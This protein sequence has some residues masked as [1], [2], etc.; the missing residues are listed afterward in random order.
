MHCNI[1]KKN[2]LHTIE[3]FIIFVA[4][5]TIKRLICEY[6]NPVLYIH[7]DGDICSGDLINFSYSLTRRLS[8]IEEDFFVFCDMSNAVFNLMDGLAEKV[9]I[10]FFEEI[11]SRDVKRI[12]ILLPE[13]SP[14]FTLSSMQNPKLRLFTSCKYSDALAWLSNGEAAAAREASQAATMS[15]FT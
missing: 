13:N 8:K 10:P 9:F 6:D 11:L 14:T 12:S 5:E 2:E 7:I 3:P 4:M 1:L 15:K